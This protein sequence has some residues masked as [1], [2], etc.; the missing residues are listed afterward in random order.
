MIM[1]SS[2]CVD[3]FEKLLRLNLKV[4]GW[5]ESWVGR[6]ESL[7]GSRGEQVPSGC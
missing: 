2:D 4:R 5:Q 1:G 3:A 6:F 7:M